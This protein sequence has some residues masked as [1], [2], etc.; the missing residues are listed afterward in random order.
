[1]V[2]G[3]EKFTLNYAKTTRIRGSEIKT[4][5]FFCFLVVERRMFLLPLKF[6]VDRRQR[7]RGFA[8]VILPF[9]FSLKFGVKL[10]V[11]YS[12]L[13]VT[14]MFIGIYCPRL[15]FIPTTGS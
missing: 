14:R 13:R 6:V 7:E 1:M 3:S 10:E 5:F 8:F 4:F 9:L 12:L 11:Y 2:S 15:L